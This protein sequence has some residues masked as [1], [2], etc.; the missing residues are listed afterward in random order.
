[1]ENFSKI[2]VFILLAV[3]PTAVIMMLTE[4]EP[5]KS[6]K[7]SNLCVEHN[8][9]CDSVATSLGMSLEDY[10]WAAAAEELERND[11]D[12]MNYNETNNSNNSNQE[13]ANQGQ[14][15]NC[16]NCH[17]VGTITCGTCKGFRQRNCTSC[18]G[19]GIT[20]SMNGEHICNKCRGKGIQICDRCDGSGISG[21]CYKCKGSGQVFMRN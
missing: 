1:M 19:D 20:N 6:E 10:H 15:V 9:N 14:L 8:F 18:D 13:N 21:D 16:N 2:V 12:D 3:L 4:D 17:G 7:S 5:Q 11:I